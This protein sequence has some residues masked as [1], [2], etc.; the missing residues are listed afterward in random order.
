[1]EINTLPPRIVCA[2]MLMEDNSIVAGVRHFSPEMRAVMQLAYGPKYHLKVKE[3]G[4]VNQ[5]GVFY[6]RQA[7]W[8]I[9]HKNGQIIRPTGLEFNP[10]TASFNLKY[11]GVLFSENL[12]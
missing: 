2:A 7:A 5:F 4:F 12:Y 10:V 6:T 11:D 9:A 3:Q 8:K 1:M